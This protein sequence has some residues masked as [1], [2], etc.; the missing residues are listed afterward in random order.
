M[1]SCA[2]YCACPAVDY[3]HASRARGCSPARLPP[4]FG[5]GR[6]WLTARRWPRLQWYT[7]KELLLGDSLEAKAEFLLKNIHVEEPRYLPARE[8][9]AA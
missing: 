6:P 7:K 3:A 2:F 8:D 1:V 5:I 9:T 4:F